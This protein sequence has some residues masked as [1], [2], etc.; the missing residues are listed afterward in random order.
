MNYAAVEMAA[1]HAGPA[2]EEQHNHRR[3]VSRI[4]QDVFFAVLEND[5]GVPA[6]CALAIRCQCV[7]GIYNLAT[8]VASRR[9][10]LASH[11]ITALLDCCSKAGARYAYLQ[12]ED[13]NLPAIKLYRKL[14]FQVLY[15]YCYRV[16]R[17][18]GELDR[19]GS[20]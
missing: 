13:C 16:K 17:T 2:I 1:R 10:Q 6:C 9:Q 3:L 15:Q 11:L 19:R 12:V 4:E 7:I 8:S 18:R 5:C 14:G 20:E